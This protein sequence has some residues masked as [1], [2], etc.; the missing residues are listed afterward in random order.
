MMAKHVTTIRWGLP[1]MPWPVAPASCCQ[2]GTF[3]LHLPTHIVHWQSARPVI[4]YLRSVCHTLAVRAVTGGTTVV[5]VLVGGM[6]ACMGRYCQGGPVG[7]ILC[8]KRC[9]PTGVVLDQASRWFPLRSDKKMVEGA[10][11]SFS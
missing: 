8:V 7:H 9:L 10:I 5:V 2:C 4:A 11:G 3:H 1:A 6:H